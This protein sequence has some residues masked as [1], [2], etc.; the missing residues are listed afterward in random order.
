ML[1][2]IM[3]ITF[4]ALVVALAAMLVT[5]L[6]APQP[7]AP[8]PSMQPP[9]Q[10]GIMP[11]AAVSR[12]LMVAPEPNRRMGAM[13]PAACPAEDGDKVG[14]LWQHPRTGIIYYVAPEQYRHAL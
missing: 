1:Y 14:C 11:S 6:S 9:L 8:Q 10:H 4:I 13:R 12:A 7:P 5:L 3:G 2:R